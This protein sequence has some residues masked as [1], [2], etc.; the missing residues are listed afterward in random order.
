MS[1][2]EGFL[3]EQQRELLR[4]MSFGNNSGS[5]LT[6]PR[7]IVSD[8]QNK[9]GKN[10]SIVNGGLKHDKRSHS[11][12]LCRPKKGGAGGRGTWGSVLETGGEA[13]VDRNDPNYDSE[14]EPYKLVT[15]PAAQLIQEYKN[16]V[17][18][19]VEEF[20]LTDNVAEAA[21][22]LRDLGSPMY[23]HYFVKKLISMSLDRHDR[24]KEMAAV[25]LSSLYADVISPEQLRKGFARLVESADDL[26]IDIPDALDILALFVARAIVD[27]ILPPSFLNTIVKSLPEE[28]KGRDVIHL[29]EKSYLSPPLH[30]EIVERRW[31]GS[32]HTTVELVKSK[33]IALLNEY[34]ESGDKVEACRCIRE[35]NVPFFHHEVV[36]RALIVAME[37]R[38]SEARIFLLLKEAADEGLITSS[39][40]S[41]GFTRLADASDDLSLDI[42]HAKELLSHLISGAINEGFLSASYT[43]PVPATKPKENGEE[44]VTAGLD[45]V[46]LFKQKAVAIIQEYFLSD[47]VGEVIRSLEDLSSP[48]LNAVFVKKVVTLAMDRKNREKE[49]ASVLLSSLYAEAIS[50]EDVAKAFLLLLETAEDTALD[51]PDAA[52]ELALF[53]A[54]A[55]VDDILAPLDLDEIKEELKPDSLG[56]EIVNTARALLAARHAGERILRC[57]GGGSGWAVE[58]A[59][60]KIVKLLEEFEAGGDVSEAC[61][62]IR[63]LDMPFFHHEVVKK[64]LVMAM[65]KQN[66][67]LLELLHECSNEGLITLNQMSKGFTR[68]ADTMDDLALDIPDAKDRFMRYVEKAKSQGW[69]M[70]TFTVGYKPQLPGSQDHGNG[71]F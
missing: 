68:I 62:C 27:D 52:N 64:A 33:I 29:A 26:V 25:L 2:P 23:H 59:K 34:I 65:E 36:K 53:L 46:A 15:V 17:G 41:K 10:G 18:Q 67:N 19:I 47:D 6:S 35:L 40:M 58:D 45:Q 63:D 56:S 49:M 13:C 48:H 9:H 54:R 71:S 14:E 50:A 57:W 51:I 28:A 16:K 20:F 44:R 11:G 3:T 1:S 5:E 38:N 66:D 8:P 61:R 42:L 37:K 60:D 32:T 39:Q 4:S 21:A 24:E 30:S 70:S 22:D 31:G 55:V 7:S 43:I 69:L 12:K